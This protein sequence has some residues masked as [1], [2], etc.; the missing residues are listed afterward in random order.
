VDLGYC[1]NCGYF[2][3]TCK[4][5]KGEIILDAERR[6]KVSKLLSGILRHFPESFGIKLDKD[7]FA[8]LNDVVEV[9]RA[10][11]GVG[12]REVRAIVMFDKKGRFEIRDGKIRAKYGHSVEVNYRWSE[13]GEVPEKLYHGTKPEN[14]SS[15]L[16]KGLLPM[17]RRE[18]HLSAT[19]EEAIEVGKRYSPNPVL[20]EIDAKR[21]VEDGFEI[22]KKGRVF[23]TD[24]VPREYLKVVGWRG[25]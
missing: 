6:V 13:G 3:G 24:R 14:L 23:T 11:Y 18:V 22:R 25:K 16:E 15:I 5:G 21:M 1:E 4:C 10:R 2:E 12:E 7:G 19:P 20:L 9:L 8:D 17:K